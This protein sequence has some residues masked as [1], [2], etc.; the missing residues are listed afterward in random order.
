MRSPIVKD[1][2]RVM[3][4][5]KLTILVLI[6]NFGLAVTKVVKILTPEV[7]ILFLDPK[8]RRERH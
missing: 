7:S 3:N 8:L 6:F 2:L 5:H 1:L 4:T